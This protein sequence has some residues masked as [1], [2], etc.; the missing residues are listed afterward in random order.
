LE[1]IRKYALERLTGSGELEATRTAHAAYHLALAEE[2]SSHLAG[3]QQ[4][5]WLER[6]KGEHDNLRAA[7]Q[8][9]LEPGAGSEGSQRSELALR[10]TSTLQ[11][12]W[13]I[14][15]HLVRDRAF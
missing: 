7:M 8:W 9:S 2:A 5:V 10:L 3:P 1:T 14:R 11:P 15:G 13:M 6:L 4:V 12:F